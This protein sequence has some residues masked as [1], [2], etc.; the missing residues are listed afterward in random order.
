V[1]GQLRMMDHQQ[2][3]EFVRKHTNSAVFS[4]A[5]KGMVLGPRFPWSNLDI[6]SKLLGTYEQELHP[7]LQKSRSKRYDA[8]A[9]VGCAEGYYAVGLGTLYE[10]ARVFAYDISQEALDVCGE[11]AALNRIADRIELKGKCDPQELKSLCAR[12]KRPLIFCDCEGYELELFGDNA[13][14]EELSKADLVIECHDFI[15]SGTTGILKERFSRSHNVSVLRAGERN[16]NVFPFLSDL[17]DI[18]RWQAVCE[19]RPCVMNWII[20]ESIQYQSLVSRTLRRLR[21]RD[22]VNCGGLRAPG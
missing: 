5:F 7:F 6:A 20:C 11:N 15:V 16:P 12:S 21:S 3:A 1:K 8:V 14:C 13:T 18:V 22:E 10:E 4:G 19:H 2:L 9:D 17:Y